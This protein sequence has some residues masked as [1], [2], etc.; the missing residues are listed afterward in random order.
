MSSECKGSTGHG[1]KLVLLIG[2]APVKDGFKGGQLTVGIMLWS[3][4]TSKCRQ[5]RHVANHGAWRT[6]SAAIAA[7]CI[8]LTSP[9]TIG[10]CFGWNCVA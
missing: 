1:T 7:A 2:A 10:F 6:S 3:Q 4:I 5:A 8:M 9:E